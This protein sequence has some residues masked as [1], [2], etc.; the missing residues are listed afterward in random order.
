MKEIQLTQGMVALVDDEDF[1][2]LN[3]WKWCADKSINTFYARRT[4]HIPKPKQ[5]I[6]MHRLILVLI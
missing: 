5:R 4:Q 1:E 3:N 6:K 2:Y